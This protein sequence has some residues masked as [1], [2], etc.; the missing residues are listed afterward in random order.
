MTSGMIDTHCHLVD[1]KFKSDVDDVIQRAKQSGVQC[2]VVCPEYASQF[3]AVLDLY[4]QHTDFVIPAIG[5][6]PIQVIV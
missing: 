6:H 5:I 1:N 3:D 2:A 4:A